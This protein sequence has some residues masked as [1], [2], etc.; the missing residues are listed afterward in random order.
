MRWGNLA[1]LVANHTP[2]FNK[3][4]IMVATLVPRLA[5][6]LLASVSLV[7]AYPIPYLDKQGRLEIQAHRGGRALRSE[8]TAWAFAYAM[9]G[10][11]CHE[12]SRR[13]AHKK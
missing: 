10:W 7:N 6:A 8:E 2:F 9:V 12:S 11:M 1:C 5:A 13:S 3:C 4:S